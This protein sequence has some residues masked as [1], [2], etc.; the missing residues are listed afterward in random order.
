MNS[1]KS[2]ASAFTLSVLALAAGLHS[3]P[4]AAQE[5]MIGEIKCFGGNYAPRGWA[6]LDGQLL[7]IAQYSALFSILGTTY[8]G[9]GRTTFA[10]PDMRGRVLVHAGS[11]PGLSNRGLG[12]RSGTETNTLNTTQLPAHVHPHTHE[13]APLGASTDATSNDPQ[14]R[15][16]AKKAR[17]TLYADP[18]LPPGTSN[19]VEQAA[20]ETRVGGTTP[21]GGAGQAVNNMQPFV[22]VNCMIALEG[23]Y[24]S[25]N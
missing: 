9:D 21:N 19:L 23:I 16:P 17:T 12:Q 25:R 24:P 8:G 20:T 4:V 14:G 3:A 10:L 1:H 6:L 22:T 18:V 7:A 2:A 15:V 5:A 13:V 11:G